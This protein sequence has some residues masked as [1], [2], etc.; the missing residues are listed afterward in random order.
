MARKPRV[1]FEGALYHVI[2]RGNHRRDI[3]GD[4]SDR[5]NYLERIEHYRER[6][7]AVVYAYILMSNHVHLLIETGVVGLSKIMQGIQFTYTQR[8]NR[9][10]R[11]VGHLFQGRYKAILCDHDAYL[12]ELIRYIHLNPA[13]MKNPQDP[14]KYRWSSHRAYLGGEGPL[15]VQT[16]AVLQQFASKRSAARKRYLDFMKKGL[17]QGHVESFYETVEQRFLG[18]EKFIEQVEKK[19]AGEPVKIKIKFPRLAEGVAAVYGIEARRLLGTERNRSWVGPRS[20]LVYAAREWSGIKAKALAEY[21]N[22]DA[23]MISR[24]HT[25]HAEKR[26]KK[27]ESALQRWLRIKSTTHA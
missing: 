11:K 5:V 1:E 26:D 6:Y 25:A 15:K 10:H 18:D 2:V 13:R 14:W 24:L 23:S 9:R 4:E 21:L 17:D 22:R 19:K 7:E 27:S 12:L 16:S 3:F 20:L 8:Y